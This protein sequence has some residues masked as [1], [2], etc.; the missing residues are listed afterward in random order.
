MNDERRVVIT[1]LGM[2]SPLGIGA[3]TFWD[4]LIDGRS[5]IGPITRFDASGLPSRI[6]GEVPPFKIADFIPKTHRKSVKLMSRDIELAV[7]A[8]SQDD[9]PP[10]EGYLPES[11]EGEL[12]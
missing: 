12:F 10:D 9:N 5:G 6:A 11:V 3:T 1:G 4:A 8:A 7:A 2:L